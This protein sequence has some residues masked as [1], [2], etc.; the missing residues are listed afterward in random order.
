[1][2]DNRTAS[3]PPDQ[4]MVKG[5]PGEI[6]GGALVIAIPCPRTEAAKAAAAM[7]TFLNIILVVFEWGELKVVQEEL[8]LRMSEEGMCV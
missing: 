8:R 6:L 7:R 5:V 4:V 2:H 1:M 3:L